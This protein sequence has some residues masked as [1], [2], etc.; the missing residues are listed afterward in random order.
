MSLRHFCVTEGALLLM[1]AYLDS[2]GLGVIRQSLFNDLFGTGAQATSRPS[3][4]P[5]RS[6]T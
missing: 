4:C 2:K 5:I 3:I 6:S 1:M